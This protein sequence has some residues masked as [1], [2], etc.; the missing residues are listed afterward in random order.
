VG[1]LAPGVAD[2]A[3]R[4]KAIFNNIPAGVNIYASTDSALASGTTSTTPPTAVLKSGET[5][6]VINTPAGFTDFVRP[7]GLAGGTTM[8]GAQLAVVN[9]T[10]TAVWEVTGS[11]PLSTD[12]YFV[13]IWFNYS[14][15]A[16]QNSPAPGT[17]TV[18]G[19]FAPTPSGLGVS[20]STAA[21]ANQTLPIPRFIE[22]TTSRATLTIFTCRTNLLFPFVTNQAGFDTGLAISNTSLDTG[23]FLQNT[24]TQ[25]GACNV[26]SFGDNAPASFS[27][28]TVAPGRTW[29]DLASARMPNFQGYVIAQCGF[30]FA[31]GFAFISDFGARNLAM[32]YLSLII[33]E[34][35]SGSRSAGSA[36]EALD[37]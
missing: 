36:G 34:P 9:G 24:A 18:T 12:S 14:A 19:S 17:A 26:F 20:A 5:G 28:G 31:H 33:P 16:N 32:G 7:T 8:S 21:T 3:T 22:G 10:A 37:N 29:V 27:T 6:P 1:G 35:G 2:S 11:N 4:F 25:T 23:L 30:Q 15:N 13:A